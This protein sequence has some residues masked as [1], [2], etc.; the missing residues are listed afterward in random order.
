VGVAIW[1][2]AHPRIG[3]ALI[4]LVADTLCKLWQLVGGQYLE[5]RTTVGRDACSETACPAVGITI[6]LVDA[7]EVGTIAVVGAGRVDI[8]PRLDSELR[9]S[10]PVWGCVLH[11]PIRMARP[12]AAT[13]AAGSH[14]GG[15][16]A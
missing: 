6:L 3:C 15:C 9:Y 13:G 16:Q 2:E 5:A 14:P 1:A 11:A 10:V 12:L 8:E 7:D 4:E